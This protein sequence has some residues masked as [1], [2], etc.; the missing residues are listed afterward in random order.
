MRLV[1]MCYTIQDLIDNEFSPFGEW[2]LIDN[3]GNFL[4]KFYNANFQVVQKVNGNNEITEILD[5]VA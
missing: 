1:V 2:F 3:Q 5:N 4:A